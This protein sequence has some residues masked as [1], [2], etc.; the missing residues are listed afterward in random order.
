MPLLPG[1][2]TMLDGVLETLRDNYEYSSFDL[3]LLEDGP[4]GRLGQQQQVTALLAAGS[5]SQWAVLHAEG[6]GAGDAETA[7]YL[8][9]L[10]HG[11][12][13]QRFE[14]EV[15]D[16]GDGGAAVVSVLRRDIG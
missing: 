1:E 9:L 11:A 16:L 4:D 2:D 8:E 10:R 5:L 3:V 13:G 15:H 12:N 6:P 14:P 7:G